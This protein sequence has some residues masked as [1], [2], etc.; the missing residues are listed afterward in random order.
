[1]CIR[2]RSCPPLKPMPLFKVPQKEPEPFAL[3]CSINENEELDFSAKPVV[4]DMDDEEEGPGRS[5]IRNSGF[6]NISAEEFNSNVQ[7][8]ETFLSQ[9]CPTWGSMALPDFPARP[10]AQA[11]A[12]PAE[13][14]VEA[15]EV[16]FRGLSFEN[17]AELGRSPTI[18]ESLKFATDP[19]FVEEEAAPCDEQTASVAADDV[20]DDLDMGF[21]M[22]DV[23]Q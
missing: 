11:E 23:N 8:R 1:M 4:D 5:F 17:M 10:P 16:R 7:D 19:N 21:E 14:N 13:D 6:E 3:P 15:A 9:S 12:A 2:D 18:F 22:D 20:D